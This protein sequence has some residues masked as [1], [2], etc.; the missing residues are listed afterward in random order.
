M[1]DNIGAVQRV[2]LVAI[3]NAAAFRKNVLT[4]GMHKSAEALRI[5]H[6]AGLDSDPHAAESFLA[7]VL[8]GVHV[9]AASPQGDS[10]AFTEIRD[11]VGFGGWVAGTEA[12]EIL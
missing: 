11:K 5:I 12:T 4:D 8:N 10:Q 1:I 3:V 9:N 2:M 6:T 7:H